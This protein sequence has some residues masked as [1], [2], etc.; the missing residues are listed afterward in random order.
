MWCSTPSGLLPART[1]VCTPGSENGWAAD[2]VTDETAVP[3]W[4]SAETTAPA[5]AAAAS[6]PSAV[7]A[8]AAAAAS[9]RVRRRGWHHGMGL[10]GGSVPAAPRSGA[11]VLIR[12]AP[13]PLDDP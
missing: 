9:E 12:F 7:V 6:T 10:S 2:A 11:Y 13:T 5:G 4:L 1:W 8:T 3:S